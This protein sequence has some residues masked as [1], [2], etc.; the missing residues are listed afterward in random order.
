M[1]IHEWQSGC[2]FESYQWSSCWLQDED[3]VQF[4]LKSSTKMTKTFRQISCFLLYTISSANTCVILLQTRTGRVWTSELWSASSVRA[5]TGTWAPTCPGSG[6][7]TWT[8]GRWSSSGWWRPSA[9]SSPTA[10]GRRTRRDTWNLDQTPA[11]RKLECV[12]ERLLITGG[13]ILLY[14]ALFCFI[15]LYSALF[16]FILVEVQTRRQNKRC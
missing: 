10:C 15:L 7:W 9:T 14:S 16:C 4:L 1:K 6:L 13:F 12:S 8:S 2:L 11:G 5:S 3:F